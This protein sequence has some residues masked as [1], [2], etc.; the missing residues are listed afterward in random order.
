MT[1][2]NNSTSVDI[3]LSSDR[4]CDIARGVEELLRTI[5]SLNNAMDREY[6]DLFYDGQPINDDDDSG[7]DSNERGRSG[8]PAPRDCVS[9]KSSSTSGSRK[10]PDYISVLP[11]VNMF[12]KEMGLEQRKMQG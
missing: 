11:V 10:L 3:S 1:T 7:S 6:T 12:C 4:I 5:A 9:S 8:N 2:Q